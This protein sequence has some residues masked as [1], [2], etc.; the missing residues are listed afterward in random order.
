M[1]VDVF[2][3]DKSNT[4]KSGVKFD[5]KLIFVDRIF[6]ICKRAGRKIS[7]VAYMS[8]VKKRILMNTFFTSQFSYCHLVW[9]CHSLSNNKKIDRLHEICL[10]INYND[11][12]SPFKE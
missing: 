2:K 3:I 7:A 11:K 8:I 9:M 1:N 5:R 4:K 10:Q 6:D 12:Q